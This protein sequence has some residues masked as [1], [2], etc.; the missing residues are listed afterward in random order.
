MIISY[1]KLTT[2][3]ER[4]L[5][6]EYI[7]SRAKGWNSY[8][9]IPADVDYVLDTKQMIYMYQP[10]AYEQDKCEAKQISGG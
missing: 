6:H 3:H 1:Y 8:D 4:T 5:T 2:P 7:M 10:L 9:E